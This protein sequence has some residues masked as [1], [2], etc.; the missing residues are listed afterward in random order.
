[1]VFPRGTE[2]LGGEKNG[3]VDALV[4]DKQRMIRKGGQGLIAELH[5]PQ[6]CRNLYRRVQEGW[7]EAAVNGLRDQ[8]QLSPAR[9]VRGVGCRGAHEEQDTQRA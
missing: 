1:M 4:L 2:A 9:T 5:E 7:L 8:E 3:H 6:R